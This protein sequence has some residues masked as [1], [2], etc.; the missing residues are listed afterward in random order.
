[1]NKKRRAVGAPLSFSNARDELLRLARRGARLALLELLARF[2]G[3]ALQFFL[4]L[5]LLLL[6]HLRIGGRAVIG[7]GEIVER[8]RQADR[9]AVAR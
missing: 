6:E 7:L 1:M 2:F 8:Q 5:L 9:L 4:Q 3:A